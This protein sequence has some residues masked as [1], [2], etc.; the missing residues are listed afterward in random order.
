MIV[1][2]SIGAFHERLFTDIASAD[3][4]CTS[5]YHVDVVACNARVVSFGLIGPEYRRT[6]DFLV[7][8]QPRI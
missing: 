8:A 2:A 5:Y 7:A 3:Y 6:L 4:L 1:L